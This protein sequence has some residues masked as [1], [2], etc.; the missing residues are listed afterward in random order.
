MK[1]K[2]FIVLLG[3]GM[4]DKPVEA[5]GGM[6]PLKFAKT[7]NM[8]S[9][10]RNGVSGMIRTI[11]PGFEPGSDVANLSVMGFDPKKY[12]TGRGPIE[13]ANM[14]IELGSGDIAFRMN[15]VTLSDTSEKGERRTMVD[16]SAD[17]IP[18]SRSHP[19]VEFIERRLGDHEFKFYPGKSYRHIM[20]WRSGKEEVT[21]TPPHDILGED[22]GLYLPGGNGAG[23]LLS[24]IRGGWELLDS[25]PINRE[26]E[27]KGKMP[28]NSLWFWGQGKRPTLPTYQDRFGISGAVISAVDLIQGLGRL[29]G[30]DVIEVPGATGWLDTDYEG[31]VEAALNALE[32]GADFVYLHIEAPDEAGHSGEP[33][34]KVK[35]IEDFDEKV[36]GPILSGI[37]EYEHHRIL[38]LPDHPTPV[39]LRTHTDGPVP[40]S[41]SGTDVNGDGAS[42]FSEQE[43]K[44]TG[45][46]IEE[47]HI[48]MEKFLMQDI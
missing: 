22:I 41:I 39:A 28:A 31:K 27:D 4:A 48:L 12:Y 19:L 15:L 21:T 23:R 42:G 44:K 34:T 3:D 2:K 5:L 45:I 26:R 36:V 29:A 9:V 35:A 33:M 32:S 16:Y 30:L 6:T 14:G 7:P 8:D 38:I 46:F 17:H 18:S 20:V 24:L 10:A 47:G 37:Q 1:N 43:S 25:H 40:F 11:L 13:A